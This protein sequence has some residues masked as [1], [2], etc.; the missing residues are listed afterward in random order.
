MT[1]VDEIARTC[2]CLHTRMTAR[3][4]TRVYDVALRPS[5]LKVTQL[6][7]LAAIDNGVCGSISDLADQLAFER[8][9][10]T[11]NLQLLREAGLIVPKNG[12]GRAVAYDLTAAGRHAI[13][14]AIPLWEQAQ[15]RIETAY[16]R[17][18]WDDTRARLRAL[19]KAA[20]QAD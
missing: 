6:T 9:T 1:R 14:K 2:A 7:L 16:G 8:T 15:A 18:E 10:L 4:V 11:R 17:A 19:R 5:G 20:W 13:A 12:T 3:A